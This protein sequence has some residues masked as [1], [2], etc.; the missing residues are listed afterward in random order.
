MEFQSPSLSFF[1]IRFLQFVIQ[2]R[3]FAPVVRNPDSG[4]L[5]VENGMLRKG[6]EWT[7]SIFLR[8]YW[9]P[10]CVLV[11]ENSMRRIGRWMDVFF[12]PLFVQPPTHPHLVLKIASAI[13]TENLGS[14][15]FSLMVSYKCITYIQIASLYSANPFPQYITYHIVPQQNIHPNSLAIFSQSFCGIHHVLHITTTYIHPNCL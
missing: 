3:P 6:D 12:F 5:V 13:V 9:I 1:C 8:D 7:T 15:F 4:V 14:T 10:D 11:N 2:I